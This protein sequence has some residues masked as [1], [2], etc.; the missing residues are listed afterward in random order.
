[1]T[2]LQRHTRIWPSAAGY[3]SLAFQWRDPTAR[4]AL[5]LWVAREWPLIVR[6]AD[7]DEPRSD[8]SIAVGLALP[9]SLGKRRLK[10]RLMRDGVAMHAPPLALDSVIASVSNPR[11][12][13][14]L[15][16]LARAAARERMVL[17][18]YGSA[19][20]QVQTGLDYMHDDS[21]LDLLAEPATRGELDS[22]IALLERAQQDLPMRLDG[23]IVFPGGDA[24]A[25]REWLE[26][27]DENRVIAKN[28]AGVALV[29]RSD[30]LKRFDR[31]RLAA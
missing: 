11:L 8:D 29:S 16:P 3:A 18:L 25:W 6:R 28:V 2:L 17:R 24:V 1:M 14:T 5:E 15:T 7:D 19:A 12:Q 26:S 20:W 4:A 23:E 22:A 9:P 31:R 10:F 21:D 13:R 30:L 27:K